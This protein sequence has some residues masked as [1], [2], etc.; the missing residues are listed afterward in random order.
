[1]DKINKH[2]LWIIEINLYKSPGI[3]TTYSCRHQSSGSKWY[4]IYFY[5]PTYIIT[6]NNATNLGLCLTGHCR[7]WFCLVTWS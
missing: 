1:M 3:N 2:E 4:M 7:L 6:V 5:M